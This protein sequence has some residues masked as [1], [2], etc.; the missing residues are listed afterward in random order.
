MDLKLSKS[1][2]QLEN[3]NTKLLEDYQLEFEKALELE[4]ESMD[5]IKAKPRISQLKSD[6]KKTR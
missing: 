4:D 2:L 3:N 6:I 5:M 1:L